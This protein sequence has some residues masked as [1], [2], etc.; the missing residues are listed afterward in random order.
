MC[1][2]KIVVRAAL[3]FGLKTQET[4][5]RV[6]EDQESMT[7]TAHTRCFGDKADGDDLDI[8]RG[9]TVI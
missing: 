7:E 1:E 9:R 4:G 8:Y 2:R 6:G 5:G 3:L